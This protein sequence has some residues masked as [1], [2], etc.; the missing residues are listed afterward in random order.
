MGWPA[1]MEKIG[2]SYEIVVVGT[3][4]TTEFGDKS[5]DNINI[6]MKNRDEMCELNSIVWG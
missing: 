4:R 6:N 3:G 2:N 5:E 1:R